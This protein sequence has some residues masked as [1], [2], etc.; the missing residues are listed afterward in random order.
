MGK[1]RN[2][3]NKNKQT[4]KPEGNEEHQTKEEKEKMID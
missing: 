2:S 1:R 3:E 4:S